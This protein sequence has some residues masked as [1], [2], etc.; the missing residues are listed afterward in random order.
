M[1][2]KVLRGLHLEDALIQCKM[3]PKK[4]AAM[5]HKTLLSAQ[6]NATHNH[7]LAGDRLL[8]DQMWVGKGV[9]LKRT[10]L[11]GRGRSGKMQK[12]RSHLT[13]VLKEGTVPRRT[14]IIP[15]VQER[16]KWWD[17]R[18]GRER[19]GQQPGWRWWP[20]KPVP[21]GAMKGRARREQIDVTESA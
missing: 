15:M 5:C 16:K 3:H 14:R 7:A 2:A 21:P 1:F 8:V 17:M 13:V 9:Y 11:H 12:Y 18:E 20:R 19:D 4:A 6:A 10:S